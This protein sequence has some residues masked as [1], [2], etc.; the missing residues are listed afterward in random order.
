[1]TLNNFILWEQKLDFD[2][3]VG[4]KFN[5]NRSTNEG[6]YRES[7]IKLQANK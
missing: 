1:V 2:E 5:P 7:V 4:K 6:E 3:Y